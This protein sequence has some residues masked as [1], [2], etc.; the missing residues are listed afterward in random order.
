MYFAFFYNSLLFKFERNFLYNPVLIWSLVRP[1]VLVQLRIKLPNKRF[2]FKSTAEHEYSST[3]TV[4][5]IYYQITLNTDGNFHTWL[6]DI[7]IKFIIVLT[8][9]YHTKYQGK[10]VHGLSY[11]ISRNIRFTRTQLNWIHC[12]HLEIR[13]IELAPYIQQP[14]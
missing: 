9:F 1:Q 13:D 5:K 4:Q 3:G 10:S 2:L 6:S 14:T 7:Q 11:P 8:F 12:N